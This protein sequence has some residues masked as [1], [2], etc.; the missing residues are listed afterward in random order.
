M[1][2]GVKKLSDVSTIVLM[3]KIPNTKPSLS[4]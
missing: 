1:P 4:G 3:R 2:T